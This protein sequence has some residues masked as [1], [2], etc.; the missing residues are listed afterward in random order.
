MG[1]PSPEEDFR[2]G[3]L[4]E[5]LVSSKWK[6]R[7][8]AFEDLQQHYQKH[9][10]NSEHA[11]EFPQL[12]SD[13]NPPAQEKAL[14]AY[15][16]FLD[17]ASKSQLEK[18]TPSVLPK[19][20]VCVFGQQRA[21]NRDK[22]V[23]A[24]LLHV[25]VEAPLDP[26]VAAL[27]EGTNHKQPKIGGMCVQAMRRVISA[28][29]AR[30]LP[31]KPIVKIL[32]SL[33]ERKESQIRNEAHE[34]AVELYRWVGPVFMSQMGELRS[35]QAKELNTAI[36]AVQSEEKP[37]PSRTQRS[38][39]AKLK[40]E[41]EERGRQAVK[42]G[43]KGGGKEEEEKEELDPYEFLQPVE[44]ISQLD[45]DFWVGLEAKKWSDRR[46]SLLFLLDLLST[47]KLVEGDYSEL[48]RSLKA[49]IE[50]DL[51]VVCVSKSVEIVGRLAVGLRTSFGKECKALI[52]AILEKSKDKNKVYFFFPFFFFLFS[53]L[54]FFLHPFLTFPPLGN[55]W[56]HSYCPQPHLG[57]PIHPS[58]RIH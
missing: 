36:A 43:M 2:A 25:E 16:A 14:C 40:K 38:K 6:V 7:M 3:P 24:V 46:N 52:P 28:F 37:V 50:K 12:V 35:A 18:Y 54:S 21:L 8:Y 49:I 4:S 20:V 48:S 53:L 51:N 57:F 22:G 39:L 56:F 5:R 34:L 17:Q 27:V 32:P 13:K 1:D 41:E 33:F 42:G 26:L 15:L 11:K 23:E 58:R 45:R 30:T 9:R 31:L 55:Q 47:P 10:K 29:G 44:V 19:L